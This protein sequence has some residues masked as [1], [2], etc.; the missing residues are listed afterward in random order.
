[1]SHFVPCLMRHCID[2]KRVNW[3]DDEKSLKES[4]WSKFATLDM[5]PSRLHVWLVSLLLEEFIFR[6]K[7]QDI[8]FAVNQ[9]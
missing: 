2:S 5:A 6:K 8:L 4:F 7:K 3:S 1:M 9:K